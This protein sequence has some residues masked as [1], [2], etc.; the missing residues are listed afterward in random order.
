MTKSSRLII[1]AGL[2]AALQVA[3][4]ADITGTVTLKGTPPKELAITPIMDD[5]TCSK[6]HTTVP[7]TQFYVV[8]PK[9][10]LADVIVSL[11]GISGKSTGASAPPVILDQKG[12]LYVPS[13][14]AVQTDQKIIVKNDDPVLHNVHTMP[15]EGSGNTA[16]NEAQL[17]KGPDLT[18]SFSKP[19][20]FL[21]FKC[22]VHSWMFAWVS[23]FDHPYF[24]VTGKDGSFKIANVP[25]GNYKIQA[26]H[27]KA[28]TVTQ[29]IEVKEGEPAKVDFT[30]ELK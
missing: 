18:F 11:Q 3:P 30:L 26:A 10:E 21:K 7:T 25:P 24:A 20:N 23:I 17:P 13:I 2:V 22:D 8:G 28:G 29:E 1:G 9:G 14:F 15:A 16:K 19:E 4:A 5:A 27:R 6:L 12:C